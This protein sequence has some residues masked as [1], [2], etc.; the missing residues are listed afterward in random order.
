VVVSAAQA[1]ATPGNNT[2]REPTNVVAVSGTADLGITKTDLTGPVQQGGFSTYQM[3]VTN[4]G[5]SDA[6]EVR[7]V[8]TL[9]PSMTYVSSSVPCALTPQGLLG[10]EV[11]SIVSGASATFVVVVHVDAAAPTGSTLTGPACPGTE[12]MCNRASVSS[13]QSDSNASN[14]SAVVAT[15]VLPTTLISELSL[16]KSDLGSEPVLPGSNVTY[17]VVVDNAGPDVA[18]NVMIHDTLDPYMTYVSDDAGCIVSPGGTAAGTHLMCPMGDLPPG[19]TA[20][21]NVVVTIAMNAPVDSTNQDGDCSDV[22]D[23]CNTAM[24]STSSADFNIVNNADSEPTDVSLSL[25]CNDGVVDV[26]EECDPVAGE[27]CNNGI[28]DDGNGTVDCA[29]PSC[30]APGFQSCNGNCLLTPQ[31]LP[32]LDDPA[33]INW[34]TVY[35]HGRFIPNTPADPATDGFRFVLSNANGEFFTAEM[36]PGEMTPRVRKTLT[37]WTYKNRNAKLTRNGIYRVGVHHRIEKSG[38]MGYVFT[39]QAYGDM[40]NAVLPRMTSQVY[41][42]DDIAYLTA[43]WLGKTGS[44]KLNKKTAYATTP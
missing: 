26:G 23:I 25:T 29:D 7:V 44:W 24:V 3:E 4:N 14:N 8:D 43:T 32:I 6:D 22:E 35:L 40:S 21:L 38:E 16:T 11:G 28:D 39:I 13:L 30:Q 37:K 36:L 34:D 18:A 27:V 41:I 17:Q 20:T 1:D 12:D 15:N 19:T 42:G 31:C 2:D 10:C 9:D 5:T 33:K